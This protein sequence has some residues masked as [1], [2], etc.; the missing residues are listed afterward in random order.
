MRFRVEQLPRAGVHAETH[1]GRA[2]RRASFHGRLLLQE[3]KV[4]KQEMVFGEEIELICERSAGQDV[5]KAAGV[6]TGF[7]LLDALANLCFLV[8]GQLRLLVMAHHRTFP[9]CEAK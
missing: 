8:A 6:D 5:K 7:Q 2:Q 4:R 1:F 3:V 9:S